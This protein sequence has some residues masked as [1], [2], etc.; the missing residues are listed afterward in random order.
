MIVDWQLAL[1]VVTLLVEVLL[2]IGLYY[3]GAKA[4]QVSE[5]RRALEAKAENLV[6]AKFASVAGRMDLSMS[7]LEDSIGRIEQRLER[8]DE[9]FGAQEEAQHK[10]DK[11]ITEAKAELREWT[12]ERFAMAEDMRDV[13]HA[14][15]K[16]RVDLAT[17]QARNYGPS[18]N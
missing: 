16:L 7:R 8:G 13:R 2:G 1:S 11:K 3:V 9:T 5:L 12:N 14:V 15:E 17:L 6:D 10:L 4:N 18:M